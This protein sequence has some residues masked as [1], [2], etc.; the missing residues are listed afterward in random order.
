MSIQEEV[1]QQELDEIARKNDADFEALL[2]KAREAPFVLYPGRLGC[3]KAASGP[4]ATLFRP[5]SRKP[6]TAAEHA[7][8]HGVR[9]GSCR[10]R[11]HARRCGARA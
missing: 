10:A 7:H 9:S 3:M 1:A 8:A 6:S 11:V 4:T 5:V 2:G